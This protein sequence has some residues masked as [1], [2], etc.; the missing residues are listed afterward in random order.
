MGKDKESSSDT[1]QSVYIMDKKFAWV[2]ATVKSMT[3]DSVLVRVPEYADEASIASDGGKGAKS[4]REEEVK[5]KHYPGKSL[6]LQNVDKNGNLTLVEDMVDLPF[7][8]EVRIICYS[9]RLFNTLWRV[10]DTK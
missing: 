7:L 3:A 10:E 1:S 2:P 8:H 9:D 4:W 5:V 6:P